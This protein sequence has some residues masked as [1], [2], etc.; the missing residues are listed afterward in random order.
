M[1]AGAPRSSPARL[2]LLAE[3]LF[4]CRQPSNGLRLP[5]RLALTGVRSSAVLWPD[6]VVRD[7]VGG[8]AGAYLGAVGVSGASSIWAAGV[9]WSCSGVASSAGS[10]TD[11]SMSVSASSSSCAAVSFGLTGN[12][13]RGLRERVTRFRGSSALVPASSLALASSACSNLRKIF[14]PRLEN[15]LS[16]RASPSRAGGGAAYNT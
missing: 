10:S 5:G 12:R 14:L 11:S 15:S 2:W 3:L 9:A 4:V 8:E 1:G 16:A 6:R 7:V 13:S